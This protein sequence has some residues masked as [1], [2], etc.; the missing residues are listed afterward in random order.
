[1][2]GSLMKTIPGLRLLEKE[3]KDNDK[4]GLV[5]YTKAKLGNDNM[6]EGYYRCTDGKTHLSVSLPV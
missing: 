2:A 4:K 3:Q 5:Y 1:M 6:D